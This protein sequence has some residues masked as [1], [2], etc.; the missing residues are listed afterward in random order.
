MVTPIFISLVS[1]KKTAI[2]PFV[3]NKTMMN[4]AATDD[5]S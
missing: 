1:S 4:D 3:P 5:R 2:I